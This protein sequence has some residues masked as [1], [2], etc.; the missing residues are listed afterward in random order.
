[1]IPPESSSCQVTYILCLPTTKIL[2]IHKDLTLEGHVTGQEQTYDME[3]V[4]GWEE[5]Y[6]KRETHDVAEHVSQHHV[7]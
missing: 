6:L 2:H 3:G 7:T 1:M 4:L 5:G